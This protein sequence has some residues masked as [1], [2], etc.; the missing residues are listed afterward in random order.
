MLIAGDDVTD[1]VQ[2]KLQIAKEFTYWLLPLDVSSVRSSRWCSLRHRSAFDG[3][4]EWN[5][6]ATLAQA[7]SAWAII[8]E[9]GNSGMLEESSITSRLNAVILALVDK[10]E[11]V[12]ACSPAG[13]QAANRSVRTIFITR[14]LSPSGTLL[15]E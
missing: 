6:F 1:L 15:F 10:Q 7:K 9:S 12:H 13:R 11:L 5:E 4:I 2:N 8:L 14:D 3:V